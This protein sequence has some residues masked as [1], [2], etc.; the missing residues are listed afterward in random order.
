LKYTKA[1]I[2]CENSKASQQTVKRYT[3]KWKLIPYI[4]K[5]CKN[6]GKWNGIILELQL[7]H[8]DGNN[9]NNVISNLCFLCPNCHTQHKTS[10]RNKYTKAERNILKENG[11]FYNAFKKG[12]INQ[13]GEPLLHPQ[14][15]FEKF[16]QQEYV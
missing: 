9:R 1:E 16:V 5:D 11:F 13:K 4:C 8:I 14:E 3:I 15:L 6:E 7:D 12:W 2:F 10:F